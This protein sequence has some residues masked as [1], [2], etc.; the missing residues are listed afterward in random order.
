M[1]HGVNKH[2]LCRAWKYTAQPSF[3]TQEARAGIQDEQS[4]ITD[5]TAVVA[6]GLHVVLRSAA[7]CSPTE[8]NPSNNWLFQFAGAALNLRVLG[9]I[10]RRLTTFINFPSE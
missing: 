6:P 2:R 9:S 10:P 7:F 1:Y 4:A 3:V 8:Q 5:S